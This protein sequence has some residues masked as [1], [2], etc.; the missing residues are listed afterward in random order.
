MDFSNGIAKK[1]GVTFAVVPS[2]GMA[3]G[4]RGGL[5]DPKKMHGMV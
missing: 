5:L 4:L 1:L 2:E 3:S